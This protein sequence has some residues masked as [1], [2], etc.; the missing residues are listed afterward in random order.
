MYKIFFKPL[1]DYSVALIMTIICAPII[2]LVSIILYFSNNRK[3]FFFQIRPGKNEKKFTIIKFKTMNDKVDESGN[4]LP[5]TYR[6]T[7][8]GKII[9]KTSI[10]EL[11]QLFNIL[12]G[13]MSLIGPRP[14]IPAYLPYY[15]TN[16]KKRH[17]VKP[18]ITGLAQV[19]GRNT[20]NW[21]TRLQ[22]DADYVDNLSFK[23]DF[24]ILIK[25]I[26]NVITSK[27]V[28]VD[29]TKTETYLNI[30]RKDQNIK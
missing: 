22:F 19:N 28:A 4:L 8:I 1:F 12:K 5:D 17:T 2:I 7:S 16:E 15:K 14:L 26:Y 13:D 25:T 24:N 9:R 3:P 30:E 29:S 18:G 6:F 23:M 11:P 20:I 27:D 21:D 10:D